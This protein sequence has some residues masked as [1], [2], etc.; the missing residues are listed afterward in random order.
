MVFSGLCAGLCYSFVIFYRGKFSEARIAVK[1]KEA[2]PLLLDLGIQNVIRSRL[3]EH[4]DIF[5]QASA[6]LRAPQ[7]ATVKYA[8][9]L[10]R[11]GTATHGEFIEDIDLWGIVE[12]KK[13]NLA[14]DK[15]D[16]HGRSDVIPEGGF[17]RNVQPLPLALSAMRKSDGWLHF[18]VANL[19][20]LEITESL[21][22]LTATSP[23]GM[24]FKERDLRSTL[25]SPVIFVRKIAQ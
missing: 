3:T 1:E 5:I 6:H 22:R 11:N 19:N 8:L 18:R 7:S 25:S 4:P 24:A 16:L 17:G 23:D 14:V 20:D 15:I 21:L 12:R 13:L 10:I 9:D 2:S